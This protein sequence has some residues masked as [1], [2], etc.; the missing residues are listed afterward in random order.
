MTLDLLTW[1]CPDHPDSVKQA[2]D[3]GW[4]GNYAMRCDMPVE[5]P[6]EPVCRARMTLDETTGRGSSWAGS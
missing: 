2:I 3:L 1:R 5:R 4:D 6:R